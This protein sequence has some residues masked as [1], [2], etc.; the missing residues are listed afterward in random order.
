MA[1]GCGGAYIPDAGDCHSKEATYPG[2]IARGVEPYIGGFA[3]LVVLIN[4]ICVSCLCLGADPMDEPD[5]ENIDGMRATVVSTQKLN[6]SSV[7]VLYRLDR[8]KEGRWVLKA[9]EPLNVHFWDAGG[10]N[11]P[12]IEY[13]LVRL[14]KRFAKGEVNRVEITLRVKSPKNAASLAIRLGSSHLVTA[15]TALTSKPRD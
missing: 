4:S 13:S 3:V 5:A 7:E 6:D 1:G 2:E 11:I 12:D 15:K 10:D 9:S 14:G 8:L